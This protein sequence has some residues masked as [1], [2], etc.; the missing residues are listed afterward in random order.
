MGTNKERPVIAQHAFPAG[1]AHLANWL[2]GTEGRVRDSQKMP[3]LALTNVNQ[4]AT[5]P[6]LTNLTKDPKDLVFLGLFIC[7]FAN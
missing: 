7:E 4:D 5:G 3:L 6:G 2:G 1:A